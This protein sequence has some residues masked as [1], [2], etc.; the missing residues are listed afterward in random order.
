M[1]C[2]HCKINNTLDSLFCKSCGREISEQMRELARDDNMKLLSRGYELLSLGRNEEAEL[3]A[4]SVIEIDP[5]AAGAHSLLGMFYEREGEMVLALE[6]YERVVELNPDSSL[7]KIKVTQVRNVI[8]RLA[9]QPVVPNRK[10]ALVGGSLAILFVAC[11]GVA[12]AIATA[13]KETTA[14]KFASNAPN[15]LLNESFD[16]AAKANPSSGVLTPNTQQP[17]PGEPADPNRGVLIP[18]AT[19]RGN[20]NPPLEGSANPK[21]PNPEDPAPND[22]VPLK[23]GIEPSPTPPTQKPEDPVPDESKKPTQSADPQPENNRQGISITK[24]KPNSKST[25]TGGTFIDP[26]PDKGG[27][28]LTAVVKSANDQMMVGRFDGAAKSLERALQMG[29]DR[30]KLNQKL[31]ICYERSGKKSEAISAYKSAKS[32]LESKAATDPKAKSQLDSINQAL[33]NLGG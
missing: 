25:G 16:G 17:D 2:T 8:T 28:G 19:D 18:K 29:G 22:F 9:Q 12:I 27:N 1:T 7:D 21:L 15:V 20:Q 11:G 10:L 14:T 32:H 5:K 6:C 33:K 13:P 26:D 23:V 4:K 31:G 30:G 24:T 3:I